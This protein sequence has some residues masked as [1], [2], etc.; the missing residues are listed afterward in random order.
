MD[1]SSLET[2]LLQ[3]IT[4]D[5]YTLRVTKDRFSGSLQNSGYRAT[6]KGPHAPSTMYT[7]SVHAGFR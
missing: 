5:P 2:T 3:H 4:V 6:S 7:H 1:V